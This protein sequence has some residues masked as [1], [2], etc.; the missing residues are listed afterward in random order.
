MNK[1][2]KILLVSVMA[3]LLLSVVVYFLV[4][5]RFSN[6]SDVINN[7]ELED[8]S[9]AADGIDLIAEGMDNSDVDG[10]EID[11]YV[12]ESDVL[13]LEDNDSDPAL[14]DGEMAVDFDLLTDDQRTRI[15]AGELTMDELRAEMNNSANTSEN[16]SE[17]SIPTLVNA[18]IT[19]TSEETTS[20]I[21]MTDNS[22]L[23]ND[24]SSENLES[25]V[26]YGEPD[27]QTDT[28]IPTLSALDNTSE[29]TSS[30]EKDE[31][32]DDKE[33][34][35]IPQENT[36]K[37]VQEVELDTTYDSANLH[38]KWILIPLFAILAIRFI[39]YRRLHL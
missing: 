18:T 13:P 21:G 30:Q 11:S 39:F 6:N 4:L 12:G 3:L 20:H 25:D 37:P 15:L 33:V 34:T 9:M 2:I 23:N 1:K 27:I 32:K 8:N 19:A 7:Q 28:T 22:S 29:D 16:S 38:V 26:N 10:F 35:K 31:H 14:G 24:K 17:G 36:E 5:P